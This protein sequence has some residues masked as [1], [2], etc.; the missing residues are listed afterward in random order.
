MNTGT[1]PTEPAVAAP[2]L[3]QLAPDLWVAQGPQ[4]FW[5]LEVGSRMTVMR[6]YDG[7]LVLH[8]TRELTP[9]LRAEL[10]ALGPVRHAIAPNRFHH[11][12]AGEVATHYPGSTLW[13][14]DGVQG[15]RPDLRF[16]HVLTDEA[17]PAW[18]GQIDQRYFRGRPMENEVVFLHRDSRTL[19]FCD[20]AMNFGP[21]APLG[22]R[23]WMTLMGGQGEFRPTRLDP[24]LIRDR[25]LARASL[26]WILD[27]DFDRVVI[28]HGEVLETGGKEAL[29]RG[30]AWLLRD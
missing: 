8:A 2:Q 7:G 3:Q 20:L 29:R 12:H 22:T 6:L 15:K 18:A 27:Q 19:I 21:R 17:P 23:M 14:A 10:D 13:I 11:L 24:L 4:R 25:A 5:G 16:D 9:A 30:Y 26:A 1:N 28:S